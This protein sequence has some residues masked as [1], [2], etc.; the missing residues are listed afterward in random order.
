LPYV[1]TIGRGAAVR[2]GESDVRHRNASKKK[3]PLKIRIRGESER[4]FNADL[5]TGEL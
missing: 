5:T 4:K 2:G 1:A 3:Y